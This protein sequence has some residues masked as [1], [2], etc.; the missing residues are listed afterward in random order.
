MPIIFDIEKDALYK[1]GFKR[2]AAQKEL[3]IIL[4]FYA[5]GIKTADIAQVLNIYIEKVDQVIAEWKGK[6]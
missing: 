6:K 3:Q 5:L 4:G 1:K 2:G